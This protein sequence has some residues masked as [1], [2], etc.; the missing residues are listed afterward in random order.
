MRRFIY[1]FTRLAIKEVHSLKKGFR[2]SVILVSLVFLIFASIS[3]ADIFYLVSPVHNANTSVSIVNFTA[4]ISHD[5]SVNETITNVSLWFGTPSTWAMVDF[6][7]TAFVNDTL[8]NFTRSVADGV[9]NWTFSV[10]YNVTDT[11]LNGTNYTVVV[12]TLAPNASLILPV[13]GNYSVA[14]LLFNA[15]VNDSVS[16]V[17]NVSFGYQQFGGAITWFYATLASG[18]W[19]ATLALSGLSDGAYNVS[20]NATDFA[21]NQNV[22]N[23]VTQF[24][25]DATAPNASLLLPSAGNYSG[26]LLF[27]ASVNDST[28]GVAFVWFGRQQL[29]GAISWFAASLVSGFWNATLDTTALSDGYYNISLNATDFA[30]NQNVTNNITVFIADNTA[31]NSSLI[32][33]SSGNY[34][35]DLLFNAS[36]NDSLSGVANVSFGYQQYGGSITWFYATLASGFLN[37][38]LDT[39]VLADGYFNLSVNATVFSGNQNVNNNI[40]FVVVDDFVVINYTLNSPVNNS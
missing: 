15:S 32:L 22:T 33:P 11:V 3:F 4:N 29:G 34:S 31:P 8:F 16:G 14:S 36:V 35:A 38:P 18:F 39:T 17:F 28:S 10:T 21:G 37:A 27:N 30:G 1:K 6:N 24:V 13:S 9:Y 25:V 40:T 7:L 19:N 5:G 2:K 26:N 23:N 12:D 20:L